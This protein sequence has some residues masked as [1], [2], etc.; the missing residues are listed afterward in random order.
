MN[1]LCFL[2]LKQWWRSLF[3][4]FLKK[5]RFF[6]CQEGRDG[7]FPLYSPENPLEPTVIVSL[8]SINH[9]IS[10]LYCCDHERRYFYEHILIIHN[11]GFHW[12]FIHLKVFWSHH[13]QDPLLSPPPHWM[14]CQLFFLILSWVFFLFSPSFSHPSFL[15]SFPCVCVHVCMT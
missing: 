2:E 7:Y 1:L 15:L 8:Q 10:S 4:L 12:H 5:G 6:C 3:K 11:S 9:A 14:L 13:P